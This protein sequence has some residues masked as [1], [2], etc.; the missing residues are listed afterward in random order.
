M[1]QGP[2][3]PTD[4]DTLEPP[5]DQRDAV[6][7]DVNAVVAVREGSGDVAQ[8]ALCLSIGAAAQSFDGQ[9]RS[10]PEAFLTRWDRSVP[11]PLPKSMKPISLILFKQRCCSALERQ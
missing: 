4:R 6:A 7:A 10:H 1:G 5:A 9:R 2:G 3:Q 11:R 8:A